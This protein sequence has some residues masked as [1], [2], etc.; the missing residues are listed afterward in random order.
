M[1]WCFT[2]EFQLA[3]LLAP[4]QD[5][6]WWWVLSESL[7]VLAHPTQLGRREQAWPGHRLR[8]CDSASLLPESN[9][10]QSWTAETSHSAES[11]SPV[12]P[13]LKGN[14]SRPSQCTSYLVEDIPGKSQALLCSCLT[15]MVLE[16]CWRS[17]AVHSKAMWSLGVCTFF[18]R[19]YHLCCDVTVTC[20]HLWAFLQAD[21]QVFSN[22]R[23]VIPFPLFGSLYTLFRR[24][25]FSA[26]GSVLVGPGMLLLLPIVFGLLVAWVLMGWQAAWENWRGEHELQLSTISPSFPGTGTWSETIHPCHTDC[27]GWWRVTG[28]VNCQRSQNRIVL[29][30]G[31][32]TLLSQPTALMT[33]S[34]CLTWTCGPSMEIC[35]APPTG[36]HTNQ[37][38][39]LPG[40]VLFQVANRRRNG[41]Q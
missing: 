17:W 29:G 6:D 26:E 16:G 35:S 18:V 15:N 5:H 8:G 39:C 36:V 2:F 37:V 32:D 31:C 34:Y 4:S 33:G 22:R 12:S 1:E 10:G 38:R 14:W 21:S 24:Q 30:W 40:C 3:K 9:K 27:Y 41:Q 13:E 7:W 19:W 20:Q 23:T 25:Y 11:S 28:L